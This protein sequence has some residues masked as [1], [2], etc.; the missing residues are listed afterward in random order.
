MRIQQCAGTVLVWGLPRLSGLRSF[1]D[2]AREGRVKT[3]RV[4]ITVTV[5]VPVDDWA[6]EYGIAPAEVATDFRNYVVGA[7]RNHPVP[8]AVID[9]DHTQRRTA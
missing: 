9:A 6:N 4:K 2:S 7:I 5:D 8:C 3:V 1:L